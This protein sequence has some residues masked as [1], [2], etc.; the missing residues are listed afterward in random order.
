M[1]TKEEVQEVIKYE[2]FRENGLRDNL[3]DDFQKAM[4]AR[5]GKWLLGGGIVII[6]TVASAWFTLNAR[7]ESNTEKIEKAL[8]TD[9]AALIIQRLDN[10][11]QVVKDK[12]STIKELDERLRSKGI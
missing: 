11:E 12:N 8:T 9:Q 3:I 5:I 7:V 2:F 1:C 6:F 4:D 10:L